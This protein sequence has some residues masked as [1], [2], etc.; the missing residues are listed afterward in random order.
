MRKQLS[1]RLAAALREARF[2]CRRISVYGTPRRIATLVHGLAPRQDSVEVVV[3]GPPVAKAYTP[4]GAPTRA[5]EGFAAKNK[6]DPKSLREEN[7]YIV[8]RRMEKGLPVLDVLPGLLSGLIDSIQFPKVMRW[9][10]HMPA[11]SRPVRWLVAL[12]GENLLPVEWG[13]LRSGRATRGL[14]PLNSPLLAI[15]KAGA[16]LKTLRAHGIEPDPEVRAKRIYKKAKA[17]AA[18]AGG[19]VAL[20]PGLLEEVT[21]LVEAPHVLLGAFDPDSLSL[22]REVLVSVMCKHNATSRCKATKA[23]FRTSCACS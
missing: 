17:L 19:V 18:K 3:K 15:P 6:V 9:D 2:S 10:E 22:P 21:D 1:E 20:E 12:L 16:Y 5:L 7:G 14:R 8:L 4:D 11:F 23:C 13:V